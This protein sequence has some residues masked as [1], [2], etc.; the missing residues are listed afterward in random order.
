MALVKNVPAEAE[1]FHGPRP[2]VLHQHVGM[3]EQSVQHG[4][5]R[6]SLEIEG[7]ALLAPVERHEIGGL[8]VDKRAVG[9]RVVSRPRRFDLDDA[10]AQIGK[11]EGAVGAGEH[12]AEIDDG[13]AG[14][15]TLS[16]HCDPPVS[17]T[18]TPGNARNTCR[19]MVNRLVPSCMAKATYSQS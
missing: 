6:L 17:E 19:S 1:P 16:R 14:K 9:A 18:A 13:N 15:R 10:S 7:D 11:Y 8:A 12:P 3:L 4:A 2:V 5:V